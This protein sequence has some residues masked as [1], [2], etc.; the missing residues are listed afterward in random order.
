MKMAFTGH[1][2]AHGVIQKKQPLK[3]KENKKGHLTIMMLMQ[4]NL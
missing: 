2:S 3:A 4:F 1:F